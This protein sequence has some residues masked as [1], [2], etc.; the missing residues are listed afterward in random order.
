MPMDADSLID[1]LRLKRQVRFWRLLTI[2]AAILTLLALAGRHSG[3]GELKKSDYIARLQV[4]GMILNDL[5]R[6]A[7][8]NEVKDS[9]RI[10]ALIV[11]IDSPGGTAVGGERLY[12][13]LEEIS[14]TKPVV[15]VMNTMATSAAYMTALAAD[16]IY[17]HEGTVTG[18]IGV[19][20]QLVRITELAEKLGIEPVS[21]KSGPL[22]AE[23]SPLEA[24][25]KLADQAAEALVGSFFEYF[26][27]L[28]KDQRQLDKNTL[29][30][31]T[32]GRVFTGAQA[33]E[34]QLVDAIGSE[35]DAVAWLE[36]EKGL[37]SSL[38]IRDIEV[39]REPS[40]WV[41]N[42]FGSFLGWVPDSTTFSA[43]GLLAIWQ[44]TPSVIK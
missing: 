43:S 5:K 35:D 15:A 33:I 7:L 34:H 13:T 1:R 38:P 19:I 39:E 28:V 14:A 44:P 9:E 21:Y 41:K 16:R 18:S 17:A 23:P 20:M 8:L 29:A 12:K 22:K 30:F 4:K 3:V 42:A 36:S 11:H 40:E 37:E 32:D 27:K 24:P 26:K 10:K 6:D 31:V 2:V 25:S